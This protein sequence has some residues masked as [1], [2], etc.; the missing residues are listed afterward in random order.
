[1]GKVVIEKKVEHIILFDGIC[2][3]CNGA[4]NFVMDRDRDGIFKFASLQSAFGQGY[5]KDSQLPLDEFESMVFLEHDE[6]YTKSTAVL[7]IARNM[8]GIW[9]ILYGFMIVPKFLRDAIYNLI[10]NNRYSWFGKRDQCRVPT[11]ELKERF[12][13]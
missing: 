8:S 10:A 1:M 2:N 7:K 9:P 5:L 12:L 3:F 13:D 4:I 11:P 6:I